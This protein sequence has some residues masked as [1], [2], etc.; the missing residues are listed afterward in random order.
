MSEINGLSVTMTLIPSSAD[1]A[2]PEGAFEYDMNLPYPSRDGQKV[3]R[4]APRTYTGL[5]CAREDHATFIKD[6]QLVAHMITRNDGAEVEA[7]MREDQWVQYYNE[8][9]L[10]NLE[11]ATGSANIADGQDVYR[12]KNND[13]NIL[14]QSRSSWPGLHGKVDP[15]TQ[16]RYVD[17]NMIHNMVY[18]AEIGEGTITKYKADVVAGDGK[19]LDLTGWEALPHTA[20]GDALEKRGYTLVVIS[21]V[22]AGDE[23]R[24]AGTPMRKLV[25]MTPE[26]AKA[27]VKANDQAH[28]LST[29]SL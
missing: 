23:F 13:Y 3:E 29:Q 18:S 15:R 16:F 11:A 10:S 7:W 21:T 25:Y 28:I 8:A 20:A 6:R 5:D 17:E 19:T 27:Y 14:P 1:R 9:R 2:L 4:F 24:E 12:G 22:F 26:D